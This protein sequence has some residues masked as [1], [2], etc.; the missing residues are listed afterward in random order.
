M[1]SLHRR[2]FEADEIKS[3]EIADE[4]DTDVSASQSVE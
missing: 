4:W 1:L 2:D 3:V